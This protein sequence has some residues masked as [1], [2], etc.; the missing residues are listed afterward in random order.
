MRPSCVVSLR[1][2]VLVPYSVPFPVPFSLLLIGLAGLLGGCGGPSLEGLLAGPRLSGE[3]AADAVARGGG[4]GEAEG[5][6]P[7]E[8]VA[9]RELRVMSVNARHRTMFDLHNNWP[10]RRAI[11]IATVR[12]F[13]PD[14]LGTQECIES[15]T[16]DLKRALPEYASVSAGRNDGDDSGEMCALFYKRDRFRAL[17]SGHFWLSDEPDE[18]GSVA[19]GAWFPRMVTWVKLASRR[20]AGREFYFFNTHFSAMDRSARWES[21]VLLRKRIAQMTEG[22]PTIVVGDFNAAE[23]SRPHRVMTDGLRASSRPLIDTYRHVGPD[24]AGE[25]TIHNFSGDTTGDRIDW[26]L[27]S[28][29]LRPVEAAINRSHVD[30]Q[31]PSDHFPVEAVLHWPRDMAAADSDADDSSG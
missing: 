30:G 9:D 15:Q 22:E 27:A 29:P 10:N 28:A 21:A 12:R 5:G 14:L 16:R 26:I 11:F 17:D 1:A 7:I 20:A 8:A 18:P 23:G 19:W 4:K 13:D 3:P 25:N 2:R 6:G 24:S 31:Y